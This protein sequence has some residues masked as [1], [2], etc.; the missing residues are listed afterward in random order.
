MRHSVFLCILPAVLLLTGCHTADCRCTVPLSPETICTAED[1]S[2]LLTEMLLHTEKCIS[3]PMPEDD[4]DALIQHAAASH[5]LARTML[6]RVSWVRSGEMLTV[7]AEYA[8]PT[9][10]LRRQKQMLADAAALWNHETSAEPDAVRVLLAHD[11]LCRTCEYADELPECHGAAGALLLHRAAC[12]GYAEAFALLMESAGI[13]VMI[14]TGVSADAEGHTEN[15]AWNLV[16]LAENWYHI[17]CTWDDSAVQ[18]AH[19]YFL[20]N[21]DT[22][23]L[24][25]VW[26][27]KKYPPAQ[28]GGY[29][30]ETIVS[31]MAAKVRKDGF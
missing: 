16:Q 18:P 1:A 15:H 28:G 10:T 30:Y 14:V 24:T 6:K 7:Q 23:R 8:V 29:R 19:T 4:P 12:D 31:D 22:M 3:F 21:D 25:H 5:V 17:D 26:D 9:D 11:Q 27:T 2:A 13:P 20:C